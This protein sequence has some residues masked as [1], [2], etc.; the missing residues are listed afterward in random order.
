VKGYAIGPAPLTPRMRDVLRAAA[1]GS[2]VTQTARE[3]GVSD[4]TVCS[5]RAAACERL[6][7]RGVTAAVARA[8]ARGEL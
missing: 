7:V 6:G 2:T 5:V 3:L 4:A 8:Y 1:A